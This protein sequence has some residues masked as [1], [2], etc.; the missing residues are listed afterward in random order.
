MTQRSVAPLAALSFAFFTST[1]TAAEATPGPDFGML[2]DTVCTG[3]NQP[4]DEKGFVRIGGM[5]QWV[6][7]K[8][9]SCA[10]PIIVLIHGG[11]GNPTTPFADAVYQP[12]ERHY[13]IVQWDQR[14]SIDL[15]Q[16]GP[17]FAVRFSMVQGEEDLLTMP[18]QSRRYFDFIEA[19]RGQFVLVPAAGHDPNPP[20]VAAQ[21]KLLRENFDICD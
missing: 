14:D 13:P 21:Y 20:M 8:G 10:N 18:D 19:P 6:R 15:Y 2:P 11:P 7:I 3:A 5:D 1:A 16:L 12:W 17:K 9:S 4:I